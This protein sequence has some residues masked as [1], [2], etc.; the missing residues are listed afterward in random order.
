MPKRYKDWFSQAEMDLK[1]A[2][3]SL[4]MKDFSWSCFAGQQAA[5]KAVK[6]LYDFL[7]GEGWGHMVVKL[8]KEL[9][10]DKADVSEQLLKNAAYLD[11]LYIPTRYPNG[12][13]SGIPS[14]YYTDEDARKAV[15]Y[16]EDILSFVKTCIR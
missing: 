12:F 16:A 3:N 5:E 4:K 2:K 10:P 13:E 9:P 6:A 1:H 14:E 7:G 15:D 8:L 11:K